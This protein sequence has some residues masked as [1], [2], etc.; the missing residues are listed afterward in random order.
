MRSASSRAAFHQ[1]VLPVDDGL[2]VD[3][4]YEHALET[5]FSI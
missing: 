1:V 5:G 3:I 4:A 2:C